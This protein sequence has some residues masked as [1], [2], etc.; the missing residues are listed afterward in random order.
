MTRIGA[1]PCM[2]V[3][4]PIRTLPILSIVRPSKLPSL[5]HLLVKPNPGAGDSTE[6]SST[7]SS[8][9]TGASKVDAGAIA[10]GV[11]SEV[12]LALCV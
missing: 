2:L 3:R 7:S 4:P 8:A 5:D 11:I 6:P 1:R 12:L 9:S 10:G